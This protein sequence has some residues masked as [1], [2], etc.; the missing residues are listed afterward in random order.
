MAKSST[1]D[2]RSSS[3][4][5]RL[6]FSPLAVLQYT[7]FGAIAYILAGA[8]FLSE[9]SSV[10]DNLSPSLTTTTTN[11]KSKFDNDA[12]KWSNQK[13]GQQSYEKID[14]LMVPDPNL[15]CEDD[16]GYKTYVLSRDP[17][18][19]YVEGFLSTGER[20]AIVELRY[21]AFSPL[22]SCYVFKLLF[23]PFSLFLPDW[24]GQEEWEKNMGGRV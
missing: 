20:R 24:E 2:S 13:P 21:V 14:S 16:H 1:S 7:V 17:L 3:G 5:G 11:N 4:A 23:F 18:V 19:V 6:S 12:A 9:I 8:P 10:V 15:V 22:R